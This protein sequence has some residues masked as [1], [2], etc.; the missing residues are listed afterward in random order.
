MSGFD[1]GQVYASNQGLTTDLE[2]TQTNTLV[3]TRFI[4]FLQKFRRNNSYIYRDQLVTHFNIGAHYLEVTLEDLGMFDPELVQEL[5]QR[6]SQTLQ[7]FEEAAFHTIKRLTNEKDE[8]SEEE[9]EDGDEGEEKKEKKENEE[10]FKDEDN[11]F[12]IDKTT[13]LDKE[14]EEELKRKKGFLSRQS[15]TIQIIIKSETNAISL[16]KL[17]AQ[18]VSQFVKIHGLIVSASRIRSKVKKLVCQCRT[19]GHITVLNCGTSLGTAITLPRTC[20]RI[21][22]LSDE[23]KCPLDPYVIISDR[24][25]FVDQQTLRVQEPPE[26]VPTGEIPRTV[27]LSVDRYLVNRVVPGTRIVATGVFSVIQSHRKNN[28]KSIAVRTPFIK[29]FGLQVDLDGKGRTTKRFSKKEIEK[30]KELSRTPKVSQLIASSIAPAIFGY[31]DIKKALSVQLFGGVRKQL[32]DGLKLRGEI[33]V[34]LLG[35]P[36]TS[37]SQFLKFIERVAPIA[38]YTSGKGSSASGLCVHP[39]SLLSI[40]FKEKCEN[41]D[42]T[43]K[44]NQQQQQQQQQTK[45]NQKF[46]QFGKKRTTIKDLVENYFK[47]HSKNSPTEEVMK[48]YAWRKS[49][50]NLKCPIYIQSATEKRK[51][52]YLWKLR[53]PKYLIQIET[54]NKKSITITENTK[55]FVKNR[56]WLKPKNLKIL[57][58]EIAVSNKNEF[59]NSNK[60]KNKNKNNS[61]N[62]N[63]VND[64]IGNKSIENS[65]NYQATFEK[66]KSIKMIKSNTEYVYDLTVENT[67]NFLVDGIVVHNTASVIRDPQSKEFY[68]EGGAFVLADDGIVCIDE[69]DKMDIH[70]RVAIHEPMEQQTISIAKAGITAVLNSRTAVLAAANPVFGRYD[71]MKT[72]LENI[73]FQMTILSRFDLIFIVRDIMNEKRDRKIASHILNIHKYQKTQTEDTEIDLNLLKR[74][75][76]YARTYCNPVL[77]KAAAALLRNN[78]V[79]IRSGIRSESEFSGNGGGGSSS[80]S[81]IP[82]TVRQL[83]AIIRISEAMA[84]MRLSK[85]AKKEDVREAIRLFKASTLQAANQTGFSSE[86]SLRKDLVQQ[87]ETAENKIRIRLRVGSSF[88]EKK[89]IDSLTSQGVKEFAIKKAIQI[90][91]GR[92]ELEYLHRRR[93]LY[94]KK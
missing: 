50:T 36:S 1:K 29:C 58:D 60:N 82:I 44:N 83:E 55:L 79:S 9:E 84:R 47:L 31:E 10:E 20:G 57:I 51:I 92:E 91:I 22:T 49:V 42:K 61:K 72:P 37:K 69:F 85:V 54:E 34:L 25:K 78:Y 71:E 5:I 27:S 38:V 94:R 3:K 15:K 17:S 88:P 28:M 23:V 53:S 89:I 48:N 21:S 8:Q 40:Y 64:L 62:R 2:V 74:Y 13:K 4:S 59:N 90:M 93:I 12:L 43:I 18:N 35:D 7:N 45:P 30:F 81:G 77:T 33:N 76:S 80:S 11:V 68:L 24:S 67:H 65:I 39:D 46:P 19:C 56:G 6:P 16:R 66:I 70:D 52:K 41:N 86:G 73:D 26:S 14:K 87:I 32:P 75:I 63:N